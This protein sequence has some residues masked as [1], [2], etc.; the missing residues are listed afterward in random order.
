ML[1]LIH[2]IRNRLARKLDIVA[3][4][5]AEN[6]TLRQQLL[7]LHHELPPAGRRTSWPHAESA[8]EEFVYVIDGYPQV[9]IDGDIYDLVPGDAVG[10]PAGTGNAHTF[11]NNSELDVRLLVVGGDQR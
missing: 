11:I 9:W 6:L 10:F 7:V 5:T 8:E 1:F 2:I 3:Y 4:L